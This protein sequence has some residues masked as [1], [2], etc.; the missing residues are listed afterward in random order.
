MVLE[1]LGESLKETLR[2]IARSSFVDKRLIEDLVKDI[3]KALLRAD[4]NVKLVL[5]L[6]NNIKKRAI[7]EITKQ[8][9]PREFLIKVVYEELVK[10]LGEEKEEIKIENKK[11]FK[12]MMVG[13]FGSGKTTTIGKLAKYY[14]KRGK[15]VAAVGLDVHRPAA[16]EQLKQVCDAINIKSFIN[17][18]EKNALEIYKEFE[19]EYKEYDLLIID[20]A[21]RDALSKDLIEEIE[22]LNKYIK[23]DERLLVLSAD[24][25]QAAQAQAEQFHKSVNITGVIITKLDG[26]AKG[27]GALVACNTTGAK[28]KFI[29]I[30]E[31]VD[32]LEPFNPKGFVSRLLGMGDIEALLEKVNVEL[33]EEKTKDLGKKFLKGDFNF[34]DLYEQLEGMKKLGPLNKIMEMIPGFSNVNIPKDMLDVQ[35][36]KLK[37]WK[38]IMQSMT[39]EELED[40]ELLTATRIDRI[41]KGSGLDVSDVR[42]LLKQYRQSK[43]MVKMMKGGDPEKLMK[44]MKGKIKF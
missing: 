10:F 13:L 24:I 8:I 42:D 7:D 22:E 41:A 33:D 43:K 2:K 40:P 3:Q 11:P 14:S 12:I 23:P 27:G 35:E 19:K 5:E 9:N 39:K 28:I 31:K 18:K 37:K 25:G 15:K 34:L 32:A 44:K 16:P 29:G 21:G 30:G 17:K 36:E 20:T 26:T 6:T 4:V 38:F 1:K